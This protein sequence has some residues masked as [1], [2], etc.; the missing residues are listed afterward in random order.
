[1]VCMP[2][3][4]VFAPSSVARQLDLLLIILAAQMLGL[5]L[6]I[7]LVLLPLPTLFFLPRTRHVLHVSQIRAGSPLGH[8]SPSFFSASFLVA[9]TV[10]CVA[11]A[12]ALLL[13]R[14]PFSV[15]VSCMRT[16]RHPVRFP[17]GGPGDR[18]LRRTAAFRRV[19]QPCDGLGRRTIPSIPSLFSL[20]SIKLLLVF[21]R[22]FV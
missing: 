20:W 15:P 1:M 12:F 14:L 7:Q 6:F 17:R 10:C 22:F 13:F 5:L 18:P 3:F 16:G 9:F 21:V 19:R 4:S 11:L 2:D 8:S